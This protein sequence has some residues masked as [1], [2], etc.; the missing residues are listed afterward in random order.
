[1]G[2]VLVLSL[3]SPYVELIWYFA[4]SQNLLQGYP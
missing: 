2:G 4:P 3:L 1:M